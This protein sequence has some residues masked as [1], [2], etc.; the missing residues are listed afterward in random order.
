MQD[1]NIFKLKKEGLIG[2][3]NNTLRRLSFRYI[4][5]KN[6]LVIEQRV[7]KYK[8]KKKKKRRLIFEERKL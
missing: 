2:N 5:M 1:C 7:G 8:R 3:D 4:W 6:I